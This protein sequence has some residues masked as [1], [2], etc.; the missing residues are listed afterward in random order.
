M[1]R[2][3]ALLTVAICATAAGVQTADIKWTP[4]LLL[5]V[6]RV[7]PVVPSPDASR[8][9]FVVSEAVTDGEKSEWLSQIH[10]APGAPSTPRE[11]QGRPEPGRGTTGSPPPAP[12]Q[13]TRGDKSATAPRW[14]P[15]G[16]SIAFLSQ[17]GGD[18][19]NVFVIRVSG[20]EAEQIT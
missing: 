9:A 14:S 15:D 19:N 18:K 3:S 10:I 20:G 5:K 8:V 1:L 7:G 13:L 16:E 11:P 17:R 2:R 4:D 6:K 12:Y